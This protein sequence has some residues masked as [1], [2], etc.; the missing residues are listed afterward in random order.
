MSNLTDVQELPL[1]PEAPINHSEAAASINMAETARPEALISTP[2]QE[3]QEDVKMSNLTDV[4]ELPLSPQ[5]PLINSEATASIK[6]SETAHPE[7]FTSTPAQD[8]GLD[9]QVSFGRPDETEDF[10][11]SFSFNPAR[12]PQ[13][14]DA[15]MSRGSLTGHPQTPVTRNYTFAPAAPQTPVMQHHSFGSGPEPSPHHQFNQMPATQHQLKY[16]PSAQQQ[17]GQVPSAHQQLKQFSFGA[18]DVTPTHAESS[19]IGAM[20]MATPTKAGRGHRRTASEFVGGVGGDSRTGSATKVRHT[21]VDGVGLAGNSLTQPMQPFNY[22]S[23]G[24]GRKS[25]LAVATPV[26]Q[27]S[28]PE[29]PV[30]DLD[31]ANDLAGQV[32]SSQDVET[33]RAARM[34]STGLYVP[35]PSALSGSG[36]GR[37]QHGRN[38]SAG[39]T[40]TRRPPR[41]GFSARVDFI[42]RPLST[43]SSQSG[44]SMST[45]RN[46][47][48]SASMSSITAHMPGSPLAT[49]VRN[50]QQGNVGTASN[51]ISNNPNVSVRPRATSTVDV[52]SSAAINLGASTQ[53]RPKSAQAFAAFSKTAKTSPIKSTQPGGVQPQAKP[54]R[55][56]VWDSLLGRH[57]KSA[58]PP[59]V[60]AQQL[61]AAPIQEPAR[62]LAAEPVTEL[63]DVAGPVELSYD[64]DNDPTMVLTDDTLSSSAPAAPLVSWPKTPV[65]VVDDDSVIIDLDDALDLSGPSEYRTP[66]GKGFNSARK[67]MHSGHGGPAGGFMHHR[68]QSA[69]SSFVFDAELGR[70]VND[71]SHSARSF[72]ME[73]VF[74]EEDD[75]PKANDGAPSL[76]VDNSATASATTSFDADR[77]NDGESSYG[78]SSP[79]LGRKPRF[80]DAARR[81]Q[82]NRN[83]TIGNSH[84]RKSSV[85]SQVLNGPSS[86]AGSATS[87]DSQQ[88]LTPELVQDVAQVSELGA[89]KQKD[90]AISRTP[91]L[92]TDSSMSS[93]ATSPHVASQ[94]LLE[95][96]HR[97]S[98]TTSAT[99]PSFLEFCARTPS[100]TFGEPG[101]EL[102]TAEDVSFAPTR[103][104]LQPLASNIRLPAVRS[105]SSTMSLASAAPSTRRKRSSLGNLSRLIH[106]PFSDKSSVSLAP[107]TETGSGVKSAKGTKR[108]SRVL[109]FFK[110]KTAA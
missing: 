18:Q 92:A 12:Q 38:L 4:Q 84:Y 78:P 29:A 66:K 106:G 43:I 9:E 96:Q 101:P 99:A 73:D 10:N 22:P 2:A 76:V 41:V 68:A 70:I 80:D 63:S 86:Y 60:N 19:A 31:A 35:L 28:S 103:A 53:T 85:S 5:A 16:L 108:L 39:Y 50:N 49:P 104:P 100:V 61:N 27:P 6:M 71:S 109:N 33:P 20:S 13:A 89:L 57:P 46:H 25:S 17:F 88:V 97:G 83:F 79:G 21:S 87:E 23:S 40:P 72:A 34:G 59:H 91:Q 74:E 64:F 67:S 7:A 98:S 1:S 44:S 55:K 54:K 75:E 8:D 24:H 30:I 32:S 105:V 58:L 81:L 102:R 47:S 37:G 110:T 36:M 82:Y 107:P 93:P 51:S 48:M 42:P 90:S 95:K 11:R 3:D 15:H 62:E 56:G 45:L 77:M 52:A 26:N 14:S 94:P 65:K 69:P